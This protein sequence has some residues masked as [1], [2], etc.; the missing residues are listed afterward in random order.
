MKRILIA[1]VLIFLMTGVASTAVIDCDNCTDCSEKIQSASTGDTVRLTANIM[2]HDG[3]CIDF[4]GKDGITF[5]GD[6]HIISGDGDFTGSGIYLSAH[7]DNNIVLNCRTTGFREGVYL[8]E[9]DN[10]TIENITSY[11]NRD[12]GITIL[13]GTGNIFRECT[14]QENSCYDF[15]FVPNVRTDCDNCLINVTGSEWRPI[16]FYN[17]TVDLQNQEFSVLYLCG[18]ND[19]IL[20]NI[21]IVGSDTNRNNG[22]RVYYTDNAIIN[23]IQSSDN[24]AGVYLGNSDSNIITNSTCNNSHHYNVFVGH[25][26]HNV[27]SNIVTC[28]SLQCGIYLFHSQYN[29]CNNI[30]AVNNLIGIKLD[31]SSDTVINNSRITDSLLHG[32]GGMSADNNLIYNNY[33][34]NTNEVVGSFMGVWNI[35]PIAG[36][37]IIGGSGI[38]GNYWSEYVGS[39]E[40]GD[41]FGDVGHDTGCGIDNL[42]LIHPSMLCGDVDCNG[43]VSAND[44]VEA[45]LRAVDPLYPL[46]SE[47]AADVDGN[48]YISANDVVEIYHRAVDPNH[49]LNCVPITY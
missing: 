8:F 40:D 19:S 17:Q 30:T 42:P 25:G 41:G 12:S 45:Y 1:L 22:L 47:W 14:L 2:N 36:T 23:G 31:T 48:G 13:Y 49:L 15:H 18:A 37:N 20:D 32:I 29:I 35:T 5:D 16:G 4:A 34:D 39:D 33:F 28:N 43:Y 10:N 3:T 7:S 26:S 6:Q 27:F 9:A 21:S 46:P 38:G 24:F 44:V 11:F